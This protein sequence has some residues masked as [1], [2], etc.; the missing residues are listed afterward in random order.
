M[1][2]SALS[3]TRGAHDPLEITGHSDTPLHRDPPLSL[4]TNLRSH[5]RPCRPSPHPRAWI[6]LCWLAMVNVRSV[7]WD[8]VAIVEFRANRSRP[9]LVSIRA[10]VVCS[11]AAHER[12]E[13]ADDA[14]TPTIVRRR[15]ADAGIEVVEA[16]EIC[17]KF[18]SSHRSERDFIAAVCAHGIKPRRIGGSIPRF[19][20]V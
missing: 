1:N 2:G 17:I 7:R 3:G 8:V 6:P 10:P 9:V 4:P 18:E 13:P 5:I 16:A 19:V 14:A 15:I 11:E 20:A 12:V